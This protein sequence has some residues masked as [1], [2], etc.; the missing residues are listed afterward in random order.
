M[1]RCG[2]CQFLFSVHQP[3]LSVCPR[4]GADQAASDEA[5]PWS[6]IARLTDLAEVGYFADILENEGITTRV[7]QHDEFSALDGSWRAIFIV[8]VPSERSSQA[9]RFLGEVHE[10]TTDE[11][12]DSDGEPAPLTTASTDHGRTTMAAAWWKP[13]VFVLI[14]SGLFSIVRQVGRG[15]PE[16]PLPG[17]SLWDA[18]L[19]T[20]QVFASDANPN[21]RGRRLVTDRRSRT[22]WLHEDTDGDGR[23]DRVR[24]FREGRLVR[25]VAR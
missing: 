19:E 22:I 12:V 10:Q 24:C 2:K 3:P 8:Q 9:A 14:A 11:T 5:E 17:P 18:L 23:S 15:A 7:R 6:S 4:C 25:E 16:K 20:D 13:V 1:S 21:D